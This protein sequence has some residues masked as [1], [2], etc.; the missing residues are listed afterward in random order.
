MVSLVTGAG[1][2]IGAEIVRQLIARGDYVV[3][4]DMDLTRLSQF[5]GHGT[6]TATAGDLSDRGYL[7]DLAALADRAGVNTV[8]AAHGVDGSGALS[9]VT[10]DFLRRVMLVNAAS[11]EGLVA[12]TFPV[13]RRAGGTFVVIA[14][15]AGLVAEPNNAAYCA[16][17][18]GVVGWV[19]ALAPTLARDGVHLRAFCPGCTETPLL[20]AAQQRFAAAQ[21]LSADVFIEHR[22]STIPI[23]RFATVTE[24]A[25]GAIYL[26]TP[27]PGR[28]V[29]LA[30]TG[31]EVLY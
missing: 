23:Q 25:A 22:R 20:F 31:G 21:G 7:A 9:Q 15:Q 27:G 11:I 10:D 13:L 17:K 14:S 24:T 4:Q 6:A 1:G 12:E 29:V 5:G 16:S 30:A 18:F 3:V 28:P 2:A 8:I 26:A 19:R